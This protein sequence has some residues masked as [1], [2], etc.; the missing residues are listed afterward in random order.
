MHIH[1]HTPLRKARHA[2]GLSL[3]EVGRKVGITDSHLSRVE[4][5]R[6]SPTPGLAASL[7]RF[8]APALNELHIFYPE[9]YQD[10][11]PK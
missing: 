8:Y 2:R 10:W 7:A 11:T 3:A 9:R 1:A 6:K 4:L 5:G